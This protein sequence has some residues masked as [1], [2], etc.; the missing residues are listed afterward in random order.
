MYR[1]VV[2]LA[3]V[4]R[5]Q[6]AEVV[7]DETLAN[8]DHFQ[9]LASQSWL[10]GFEEYVYA[11]QYRGKLEELQRQLHDEAK[12]GAFVDVKYTLVVGRKTTE[13]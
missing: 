7:S 2:N 12:A 13:S 5:D 11:Q 3:Q 6:G 1:W 9:P 4:L 8:P 10:A